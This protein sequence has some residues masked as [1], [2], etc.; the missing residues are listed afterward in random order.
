[1]YGL[2]LVAR[3]GIASVLRVLPARRPKLLSEAICLRG[4]A[5]AFAYSRSIAKSLHGI[6]DPDVLERT[7]SIQDLFGRSAKVF[8]VGL[9]ASEEGM[10]LDAFYMLPDDYL[11]K[12]DVASMA[13]TLESREPYLDQTLIEWAMKLPLNWKIRRGG[14]K[15]LLRKLCNRYVPNSLIDRP[16]MGFGAPIGSWLRGPLNQ[17]ANDVLGDRTVYSKVPLNRKAVLKL[18]TLH[19]AGLNSSESLLWAILMLSSFLSQSA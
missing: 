15:F 12:V 18:L 19:E 3:K 14:R 16:K 1:L 7:D 9:H 2:P 17:W 4:T 5:E 8:P 13:F 6:V 10:R 11:Q